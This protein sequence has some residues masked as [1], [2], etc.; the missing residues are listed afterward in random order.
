MYRQLPVLWRAALAH[1]KR[2]NPPHLSIII[3][4]NFVECLEC[5]AHAHVEEWTED[6]MLITHNGGNEQKRISPEEF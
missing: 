6:T 2:F 1:S 3:G 4:A 5:G